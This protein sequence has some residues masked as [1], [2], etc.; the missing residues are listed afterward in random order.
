[1]LLQNLFLIIFATPITV[2]AGL[3][4]LPNDC[5]RIFMAGEKDNAGFGDH[6]EAEKTDCTRGKIAYLCQ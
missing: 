2:S 3:E 1:M 4:T 5:M 6:G